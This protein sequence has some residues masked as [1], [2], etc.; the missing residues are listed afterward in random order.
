MIVI[1]REKMARCNGQC[2]AM[3]T[4][5]ALDIIVVYTDVAINS[6]L[7]NENMTKTTIS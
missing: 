2:R 1:K 7:T 5:S 6:R 3:L 4:G